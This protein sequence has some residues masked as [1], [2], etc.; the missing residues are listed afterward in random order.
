MG[1]EPTNPIVVQGDGTVLVEVHA[2]KYNEARDALARFAEL[3]KS[4]EHVHT[5]QIS[6]LSIWNAVAAGYRVEEMVTVLTAYS[7][8]DVPNHVLREIED[9]ASRYGRLKLFRAEG[10]WIRLE[11]SDAYLAEEI[12]HNKPLERF[13]ENRVD[14]TSFLVPS[15]QRGHL[16]LELT[17]AGWPP[18]D[19]V[20][21]VDGEVLAIVPREVAASGRRF[22]LRAYQMEAA[23]VFH[24]GG[25]ARG[26]SGVIVLPCG[27]GK[28]IV[29]IA[30][31]AKLCTSTLVLT[32][33]VS[34]VRQWKAELLDKTMLGEDLIGEYSGFAKEIRPVTITTYQVL[35]HRKDTQAEFTHLRLFNERNWGL[36]IYDE[37]HVLPAPVFQFTADIQ[38]RR[39]LGLTATLVREDGK[40][41]EVFALIGPKK[42]DVPW[43]DLER[44]GWIAKALCTEVR[45]PLPAALRMDYA[46]ADK[47][48]RF[49]I[50][51]ENPDKLGCIHDI[52]DRHAGECTL[53]IGQYISQ[54][55]TLAA[56]LEAPIIHGSTPQKQRDIIF[57]QF[58]NG[59]I[60]VLV[61]SKVA[62][63]ALDLPDAQV[64]IQV[65]GTFGSRQEEAQR[66]GRILRPK[67]GDNMA[68][69][70]TLTTRDTTEIEFARNRQR[71][72]TEQG[73]AYDIVDAENL[74]EALQDNT[75]WICH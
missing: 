12:V 70:Y 14:A 62:N 50:A 44:Q 48:Q 58:R 53:V 41:N 10:S 68:H 26:G 30:T 9:Y 36:V 28:T 52:L 49:R 22:L 40:E 45:L 42:Y 5:Y 67:S 16:K 24:Q 74:V 6:P 51:S 20:G 32:T 33:S 2:P 46:V 39:R 56:E 15:A 4:P 21:Y 29:G 64:A 23:D 69:F 13:L 34:A 25:S 59:R 57:E 3:V 63:F 65:S 54:L 71:F 8:Y 60:P 55:E 35:T 72:L 47:R 31:M 61:V 73:Y 43:K 19:L 1:Y 7:K 37:V 17:N 66:L 75:R 38:A 18:E 27:A 11:A